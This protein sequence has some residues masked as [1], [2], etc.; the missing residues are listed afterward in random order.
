MDCVFELGFFEWEE[1]FIEFSNR[2]QSFASSG[3]E[4]GEWVR[5]RAGKVEDLDGPFAGLL[6]DSLRN[7]SRHN[8]S[9]WAGV[10]LGDPLAE[11]KLE[12]GHDDLGSRGDRFNP[13][14]IKPVGKFRPRD[15]D[16]EAV[17]WGVGAAYWDADPLSSLDLQ[18]CPVGKSVTEIEPT[19]DGDADEDIPLRF[20]GR[21]ID[22]GMEGKHGHWIPTLYTL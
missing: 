16:D 18:I 6:L 11:L 19:L 9:K 14:N 17:G 13:G 12:R 20:G 8:Q 15:F 3:G 4:L 5:E 7:C 22:V 1:V 10:V 2:T 21:R